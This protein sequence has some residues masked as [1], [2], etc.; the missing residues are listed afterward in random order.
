M[1]IEEY[2]N[3]ASQTLARKF[4]KMEEDAILE[5]LNVANVEIPKDKGIVEALDERDFKIHSREMVNREP[6]II[7][8]TWFLEHNGKTITQRDV[9]LNLGV[10]D[11]R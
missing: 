7:K 9:V 8:T 2:V 6:N 10:G 11:K 3:K 5:L 4:A 1:E